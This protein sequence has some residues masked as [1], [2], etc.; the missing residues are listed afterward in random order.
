MVIEINISAQFLMLRENIVKISRDT[1]K[2]YH[3]LINCEL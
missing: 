2:E 1:T 3:L